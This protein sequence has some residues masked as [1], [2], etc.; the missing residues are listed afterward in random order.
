MKKYYYLVIICLFSIS[1]VFAQF[2]TRTNNKDKGHVYFG[3]YSINRGSE[4]KIP[5]NTTYSVKK[6][7]GASLG[8][9]Y[10]KYLFSINA[11]LNAVLDTK[12]DTVNYKADFNIRYF[13]DLAY[14]ILNSYNDNYFLAVHAGLGVDRLLLNTEFDPVNNIYTNEKNISS[15]YIPFGVFGDL[16][17]IG[18]LHFR[19]GVDF[20][21]TS[22]NH[23]E[24]KLSYQGLY[25]GGFIKF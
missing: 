1:N 22:S 6:T 10:K 2:N 23:V 4:E 21:F 18:P 15:V 13:V 8:Y 12:V 17:L 14:P 25:L 9:N 20:G 7:Y 16:K 3:I 19:G 5:I 24:H 11:A